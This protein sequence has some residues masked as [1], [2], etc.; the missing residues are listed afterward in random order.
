VRRQQADG[1]TGARRRGGCVLGCVPSGAGRRPE[2]PAS[3]RERK[4]SE[5]GIDNTKK[6]MAAEHFTSAAAA[7][8]DDAIAARFA[9]KEKGSGVGSS[10]EWRRRRA[11]RRN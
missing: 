2:G 7:Q 11:R 8:G 5:G 3:A 4:E 6:T 9:G 10:C 1:V